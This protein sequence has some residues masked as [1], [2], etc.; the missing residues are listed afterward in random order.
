MMCN[1]FIFHCH[2]QWVGEPFLAASLG[3]REA[4]VPSTPTCTSEQAEASEEDC[5]RTVHWDMCSSS[6]LKECK[7]DNM[8]QT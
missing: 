1:L 3:A 7:R 8:Y 5:H 6:L 2:R 4:D